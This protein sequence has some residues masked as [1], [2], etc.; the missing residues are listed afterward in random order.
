MQTLYKSKLSKHLS[1]PI[2]LETLSQEL[3]GVR[4]ADEISVRFFW[5]T[6]DLKDMAGRYRILGC[7]F[8]PDEEPPWQLEVKAVPRESKGKVRRAL[9]EQGIPRLRSWLATA[10]SDFW[11]SDFH[12]FVVFFDELS[13][14]LVYEEPS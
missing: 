11:L 3:V 6:S 12:Y 1:Y 13:G 4:Q 14:E 7:Q 5:H 2:G 10:R 8:A 9:L